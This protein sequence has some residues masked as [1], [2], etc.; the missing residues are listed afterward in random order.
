MS[1]AVDEGRRY[2][3]NL[4]QVG[5]RRQSRTR[6]RATSDQCPNLSSDRLRSLSDVQNAKF[7]ERNVIGDGVSLEYTYRGT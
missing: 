1:Q 6:R 3:V 4:A 7:G 5:E 2:A